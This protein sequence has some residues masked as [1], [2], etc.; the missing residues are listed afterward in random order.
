MPVIISS[1]PDQ[2][3]DASPLLSPDD[4]PSSLD[5]SHED[6]IQRSLTDS[7]DVDAIPQD[8]IRDKTSLNVPS[9]SPI[10]A[11]SHP[12]D[13]VLFDIPCSDDVCLMEK[14]QQS[15]PSHFPL[16]MMSL[17]SRFKHTYH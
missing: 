10:P 15:A 4:D 3:E 12:N 9:D 11:P 7:V 13:E 5:I 6:L 14:K 8:I 2:H 1:P 16:L 17:T